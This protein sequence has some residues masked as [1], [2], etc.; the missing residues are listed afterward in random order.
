MEDNKRN[1]FE[2]VESMDSRNMSVTQIPVIKI[3][4]IKMSL[5]PWLIHICAINHTKTIYKIHQP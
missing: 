5:V 4:T 2:N 1:S 3:W